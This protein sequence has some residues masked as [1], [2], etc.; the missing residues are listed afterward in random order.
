MKLKELVGLSDDELGLKVKGFKKELFELNYK[1]K[2]GNVEKPSS[3][4]KLKHDIAR[5]YTILRERGLEH[6]RTSQPTK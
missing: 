3:F 4:K 2:M 6:E 1:R 5:I